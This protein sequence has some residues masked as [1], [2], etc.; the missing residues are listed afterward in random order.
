MTHV[1][2]IAESGGATI[3]IGSAVL[4]YAN[5]TMGWLN[6]NSAGIL[7]IC[8]FVGM[9]VGIL[10][11]LAKKKHMAELVAFELRQKARR[12]EK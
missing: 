1:S 8:G 9:V 12:G 3:A 6:H 2:D 4:G 11:H 5:A 10:G 7:A